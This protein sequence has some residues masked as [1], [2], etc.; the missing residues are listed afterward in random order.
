M[1]N[2]RGF[3]ALLNWVER[4]D[5]WSKERKKKMKGEGRASGKGRK[6]REDSGKWKARSPPRCPLPPGCALC[7][8]AERQ[9]HLPSG[10]G[11]LLTLRLSLDFSLQGALGPRWAL[12]VAPPTAWKCFLYSL[13]GPCLLT[14]FSGLS[15]PGRHLLLEPSQALAGLGVSSAPVTP[16]VTLC[17]S[18]LCS[19]ASTSAWFPLSRKS[20]GSD[21]CHS[22]G[23]SW[24]AGSQ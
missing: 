6:C 1:L 2:K 11:A 5:L 17:G 19:T 10:S 18:R 22:P 7:G 23:R 9:G 12:P 8:A 16:P 13:L 3:L 24:G 20:L 21:D 15:H 14:L 4:T